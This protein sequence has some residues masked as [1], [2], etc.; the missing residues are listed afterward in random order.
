[1]KKV[2]RK[3]TLRRCGRIWTALSMGYPDEWETTV[4]KRFHIMTWKFG[5]IH[6]AKVLADYEHLVDGK[7]VAPVKNDG[8]VDFYLEY[9]KTLEEA[10]TICLDWI[11]KFQETGVGTPEQLFQDCWDHWPTLYPKGLR[12]PVIDHCFFTIGGGYSWFD[13]ALVSTSPYAYIESQKRDAQDDSLKKALAATK[14]L[15]KMLKEKYKLKLESGEDVDE[16]EYLDFDE[17]RLRMWTQDVYRFY[18]ACEEYSNVCLVPDDV[19]PEWL[20]LAYE[21]ALLLRDKSGLPKKPKSRIFPSD[22]TDD[23][24][25]RMEDNRILGAKVVAD[26]ERRFPQ[27]VREANA[28]KD[29]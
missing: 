24:I 19:K 1:M 25:K 4:D 13:G 14:E 22:W 18:P 23:D 12:V 7:P 20:A 5:S 6:Q 11:A 3:G 2:S 28:K 9:G 10:M 27:L 17:Q 16:D 26:L 15:T 29:E 21:A 8:S